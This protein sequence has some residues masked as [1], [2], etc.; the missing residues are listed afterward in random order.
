MHSIHVEDFIARIETGNCAVESD[1]NVMPYTKRRRVTGARDNRDKC[2]RPWAK[3]VVTI[4][5]LNGR[6][7]AGVVD[8]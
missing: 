1:D 4:K 2:G 7:T 6:E 3:M 8:S 5:M